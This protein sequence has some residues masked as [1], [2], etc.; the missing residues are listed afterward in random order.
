MPICTPFHTLPQYTHR[1]APPHSPAPAFHSLPQPFSTPAHLHSFSML[2][3]L[4]SEGGVRGPNPFGLLPHHSFQ[5]VDMLHFPAPRRHLPH[6]VLDCCTQTRGA[7]KFNF[8][9]GV[10]GG[11]GGVWIRFSGTLSKRT[12]L[13]CH[14]GPLRTERPVWHLQR[15]NKTDLPM[16]PLVRARPTPRIAGEGGF[17]ATSP[18]LKFQAPVG[19][20][21]CTNERPPRLTRLSPA[22]ALPHALP[23]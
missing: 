2:V 20:H 22:H 23:P 1:H 19:A 16:E 15:G 6:L 11:R 14:H 21:R 12:G 17:H 10:C 8:S 4:G 3:E 13:H 9:L 18:M 5:T 7:R